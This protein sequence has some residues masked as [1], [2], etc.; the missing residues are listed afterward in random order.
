[1][2]TDWLFGLLPAGSL[3]GIAAWLLQLPFYTLVAVTCHRVIVLGPS[4][5]PAAF[6]LYWGRRETIFLGWLVGVGLLLAALTLFDMLLHSLVDKSAP[7]VAV[8]I[9]DFLSY[10]FVAYFLMRFSFVLPAA[11]LEHRLSFA[12]SWR[13]TRGNG[14]VLA[15]AMCVPAYLALLLFLGL[16]TVLADATAQLAQVPY[17][18]VMLVQTVLHIAVL[19][20][21]YKYL[22]FVSPNEGSTE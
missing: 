12:D 7:R 2:G 5:L 16:D 9:Y 19:S 18:L 13:V 14:L 22:V 17:R 1:M 11:A 21:A 20:I 10:L 4:Q 6:G 8:W 3:S 15:L